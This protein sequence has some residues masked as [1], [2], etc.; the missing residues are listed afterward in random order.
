MATAAIAEPSE[1]MRAWLGAPAA[2]PAAVGD[3]RARA[4]GG[5]C[6]ERNGR[7]TSV[8]E[9]W[10]AVEG[11]TGITVRVVRDAAEAHGTWIAV[12]ARLGGA[13]GEV[14]EFWIAI[15]APA[16]MASA[17]FGHDAAGSVA[18]ARHAG[19]PRVLVAAAA[20]YPGM[21]VFTGPLIVA[22]AAE[23]GG[24]VVT[25][26]LVAPTA[27]ALLEPVLDHRS[28]RRCGTAASGAAIYELRG[29]AYPD[30]A[31]FQ[32]HDASAR[33]LSY[34]FTAPDGARWA[35]RAEPPAA[36]A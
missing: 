9:P 15:H 33:L 6:Y 21:R 16:G 19:A 27:D 10:L 26:R 36:A 28:A 29:G 22:L 7:A 8:R 13:G 5:Y 25:P 30:G 32:L 35:V 4:A 14:R 1:W 34:E 18:W 24:P 12:E 23:R 17:W 3:E 31:R 2:P 11:V 20:L